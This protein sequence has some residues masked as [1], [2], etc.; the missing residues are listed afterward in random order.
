M[1]QRVLIVGLGSI[2]YRHARIA[3]LLLPNADIRVLRR[4]AG[5]QLPAGINGFFINLE[6]AVDFRPQLVLVTNPAP[7]HVHTAISFARVGSHIFVEK[8]LATSV[9]DADLLLAACRDNGV[10]L[11]VGYN[12]RFL[13]TLQTFRRLLHDNVIGRILSVRCEVGQYLPAWRPGHDYRESVSARRELG[14]GVLLELSHEIDYLRW[15]FGDVQWVRAGLF[16]LSTLEI[17]VEDTVHMLLGF[18]STA[19]AGPVAAVN[20][21]FIRQDVSRVCTAIGEKGSLRWDGVAGLIQVLP[22]G[23]SSWETLFFHAPERDD[24]YI[25][26]WRALLES[27][28]TGCMTPV[29]GEEGRAVLEILEAAR[30]SSAAQGQ[31][32]DITWASA[33]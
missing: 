19:A 30:R 29:S 24:S 22:I 7:L 17:D 8:P 6:Q 2:G 23:S 33:K 11:Q 1:I 13:P 28:G 18:G 5:G 9:N 20:L 4:M 15:I 26:E 14:G 16:R 25:A 3:R 21:D 12:L 10:V 32:V 27:I 31:Q